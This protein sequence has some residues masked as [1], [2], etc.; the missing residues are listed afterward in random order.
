MARQKIVKEITKIFCDVCEEEIADKNIGIW[1][2]TTVC[3]HEV[4]EEFYCPLDLCK[5]CIPMY[6][7]LVAKKGVSKLTAQERYDGFRGNKDNLIKELKNLK[8]GR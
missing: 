6:S 4:Q 3:N 2:S 1:Y 5:V 8:D 7:K